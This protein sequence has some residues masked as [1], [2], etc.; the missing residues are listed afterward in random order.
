MLLRHRVVVIMHDDMP[1]TASSRT[2]SVSGG[3]FSDS[4]A[5]EYTSHIYKLTP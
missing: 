5:H 4:F 2:I 3:A 1:G